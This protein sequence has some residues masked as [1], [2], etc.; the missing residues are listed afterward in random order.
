MEEEVFRFTLSRDQNGLGT[1]EC[2]WYT[3]TK[4]TI[5]FSLPSVLSNTNNFYRRGP[6]RHVFTNP[7]VRVGCGI[8]SIFLLCLTDLNIRFL[9]LRL[10]AITRI[11]SPICPNILSKSVRKLVGFV[12]FR[13]GISTMWNAN[14]LVQDLNSGNRVFFLRQ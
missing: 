3:L 2:S 13:K 8:R 4:E 5:L 7:S 14:S 12:T 11:K 6:N 1:W 10:V 9:S